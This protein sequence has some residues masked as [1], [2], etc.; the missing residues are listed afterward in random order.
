[1]QYSQSVTYMCTYLPER[2]HTTSTSEKSEGGWGEGAARIY[3]CA[4][5]L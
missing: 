5:D 3:K 4:K 2:I 1:M